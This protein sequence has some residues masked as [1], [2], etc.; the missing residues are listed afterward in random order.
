[1]EPAGTD[2]RATIPLAREELEVTRR[3][4]DTGS[5][6][7]RKVV[8]ERVE[9]VADSAISEEVVVDR[10]PVNRVVDAP[11]APRQ[12]G[13]VMVIPV[14]EEIVTVRREWLLKEELRVS[15]RVVQVPVRESV[16]L[17][18]EDV[19]VERSAPAEKK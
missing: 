2:P 11:S 7:V 4:V 17:R 13:D 10:V 16:V 1:M 15:K 5:V 14:F 18:E 12:E 8:S 6:R 19:V 3:K 9:H